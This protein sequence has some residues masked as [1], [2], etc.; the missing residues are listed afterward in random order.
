MFRNEPKNESPD[1]HYPNSVDISTKPEH[2][3]S[4]SDQCGEDNSAQ[5]NTKHFI[6]QIAAEEA[7]HHVR[8]RVQ[9]CKHRKLCHSYF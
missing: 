6:D 7:Q 5:S 3:Y 2:K 1:I 4:H 8:P 9:A